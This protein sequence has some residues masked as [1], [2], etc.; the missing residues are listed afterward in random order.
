MHRTRRYENHTRQKK[1]NKTATNIQKN[2]QRPSKLILDT[3]QM[4]RMPLRVRR[5]GEGRKGVENRDSG[6]RV[7][8]CTCKLTT[9]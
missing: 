3:M 7:C 8:V 4:R 1:E 5:R 6:A 9:V 2:D